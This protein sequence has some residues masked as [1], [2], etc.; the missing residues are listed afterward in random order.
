M[1]LRIVIGDVTIGIH[2]QDF[3]YIFSVGSGGMESLYK[4]GKEWL[5][6]SPR[7]AYWRAVTDNDR[8]CGFAFRSA[9]WSA[10]G[11]GPDGWRGDCH[12]AGT[13]E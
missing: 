2:G 11:R 10:A 1:A 7:P 9:V 5:Y 4:D 8:G 12:P 13:G 6:R 3:S